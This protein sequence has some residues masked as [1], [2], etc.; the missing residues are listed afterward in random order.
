MMNEHISSHTRRFRMGQLCNRYCSNKLPP[1]R[2]E[3]WH[4]REDGV[5]WDGAF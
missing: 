5:G 1:V 2:E 4:T 3:L